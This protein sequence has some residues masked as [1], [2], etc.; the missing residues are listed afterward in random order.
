[1]VLS[2]C[3]LMALTYAKQSFCPLR[4]A[5]RTIARSTVSTSLSVLGPTSRALLA[6]SSFKLS[7]SAAA[8][9]ASASD[10]AFVIGS[11]ANLDTHRKP[12]IK[13]S[14]SV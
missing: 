1:M 14:S 10:A 4:I 12:S 5:V 11:S 2:D 8:I 6:S 3:F 7:G 13:A 9:F